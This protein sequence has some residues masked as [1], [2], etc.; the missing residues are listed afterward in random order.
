MIR[1]PMAFGRFCYDFVVGDTPELAIGVVLVI[2]GS[3]ALTRAIGPGGFW[4]L[5]VGVAALLAAS[6][7]RGVSSS[8]S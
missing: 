5:P 7:W 2:V 8:P 4:L 6:L 3:W 1:W